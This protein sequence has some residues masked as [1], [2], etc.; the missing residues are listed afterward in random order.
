M[1]SRSTTYHQLA[2]EYG[3]DCM[4][5]VVSGRKRNAVRGQGMLRSVSRA[6]SCIPIQFDSRV[7]GVL[8]QSMSSSCTGWTVMPLSFL[9]MPISR[10]VVLF[11]FSFLV[12]S[13]R[14]DKI[15]GKKGLRVLLGAHRGSLDSVKKLFCYGLE[16]E[17]TIEP[18]VR[19]AIDVSGC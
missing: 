18:M 1:V 2:G 11:S 9:L 16:S 4:M 13:N 5:F 6:E 14:S 8:L 19:E 12:L 10:F 7:S 15:A 17:G 3:R